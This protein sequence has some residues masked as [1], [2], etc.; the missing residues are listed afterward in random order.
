M[1]LGE[2]GLTGF[3]SPM[4]EALSVQGLQ[5]LVQRCSMRLL[6]APGLS[7]LAL[8]PQG[9]GGVWATGVVKHHL[10]LFI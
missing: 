3:L 6:P 5:W 9:H 2:L 7:D 8:I 4:L 1:L 10:L